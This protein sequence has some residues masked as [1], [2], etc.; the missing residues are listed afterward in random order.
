MNKHRLRRKLAEAVEAVHVALCNI[1]REGLHEDF[2][3]SVQ[4]LR[5]WADRLEATRPTKAVDTH[6]HNWV[7]GTN[8]GIMA[9]CSECGFK[10]LETE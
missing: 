3:I 1:E 2:D 5:W 10:L 7:A 6:V 8:N 9:V 4:R